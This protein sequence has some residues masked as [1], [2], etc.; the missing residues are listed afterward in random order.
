MI[1]IWC[2]CVGDKYSY[3]HVDSLNRMVDKNI[4]QPYIFNVLTESDKPGWWA[5][6]DLFSKP[7]PALYFDLD[8]VIVND[9]TPLANYANATIAATKNWARSGH[10]GFQSSVLCWRSQKKD[11]PAT[12]DNA[13][14]GPADG[15]KHCRNFGWYSDRDGA[16][17]WG[18]QEYLTHNYGREITEIEPGLVVSY[19]YHC[20][21]GPPPPKAIA[22]CF[23]GK[24]DYWEVKEDWIL[25]A[26]S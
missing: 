24:P 21:N 16:R 14:L 19:K 18:D 1:N 7:G 12:F 15:P 20:Q 5:K 26:L 10:G 13:R 3:K 22:V 4:Y 9:I 11:I 25:E 17:H 8:T 2:V 23:H 6:L